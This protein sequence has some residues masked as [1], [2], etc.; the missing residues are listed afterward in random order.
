MHIRVK[1]S[2]K[3]FVL[4]RQIYYHVHNL[5]GTLIKSSD[6]ISAWIRNIFEALRFPSVVSHFPAQDSR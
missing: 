6:L 2:G 5:G 4:W 3:K 1:E